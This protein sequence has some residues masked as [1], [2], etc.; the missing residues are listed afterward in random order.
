MAARKKGPLNIK[1]DD[2]EQEIEDYLEKAKRLSPE[3]E[4]KEITLAQQAAVSHVRRKK[5]ERISIRVFAN[6]LQKIK[7]IADE[8][9][10]AYQTFITSV[11][12][13]FVINHLKDRH[14]QK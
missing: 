12:H 3:E 9:G 13:K 10:L 11:L 2:Y 4:Q 6:D 14:Q 5:E 7:E 8:E 1:L